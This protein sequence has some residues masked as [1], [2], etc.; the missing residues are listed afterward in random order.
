MSEKGT[1][2]R[3]SESWEVMDLLNIPMSNSMA[4]SIHFD[5]TYFKG[6]ALPGLGSQQNVKVLLPEPKI[7]YHLGLVL[8]VGYII[9]V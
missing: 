2:H 3:N 5:Q 8:W 6:N 9:Y 4:Q 7:S 1:N